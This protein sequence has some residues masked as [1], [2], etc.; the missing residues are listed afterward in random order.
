M[1]A[2]DNK[3]STERLYHVW[4][5]MKQRCY[6]PNNNRYANYGAKGVTVCK[7]WLHDYLAFRDWALLAGYDKDAP[8]GKCT[9]DRID[10][11]GNYEPSNCRWVDMKT[12]VSNKRPYV[13]KPTRVRPVIMIDISGNETLFCSTVEAARR[14]GSEHKRC[15]INDCC[16]GKR[17]TAYGFKWR[18]A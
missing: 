7:E 1:T 6:N 8:R 16:R 2:T 10:P 13:Q 14:L 11:L 9:L 17:P 15:L 5:S 4:V 12:Q 3:T 18:Y